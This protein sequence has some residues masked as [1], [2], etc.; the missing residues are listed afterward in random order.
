M[1]T[2]DTINEMVRFEPRSPSSYPSFKP[3]IHCLIILLVIAIDCFS[4][5]I[6]LSMTS[7]MYAMA[8]CCKVSRSKEYISAGPLA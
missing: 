8:L 3:A 7:R 6:E 4:F 2:I 1:K 5:V